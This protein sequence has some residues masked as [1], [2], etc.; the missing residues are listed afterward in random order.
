MNALDWII[1][2]SDLQIN[3]NKNNTIS[4]NYI[5]KTCEGFFQR[6]KF[7]KRKYIIKCHEDG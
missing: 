4:Y 6:T 3:N 5:F 1:M 2:N 7:V